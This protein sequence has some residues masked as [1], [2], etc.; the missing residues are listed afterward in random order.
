MIKY[1]STQISDLVYP[2]STILDDSLACAVW[3]AS[4]AT[5]TL[6]PQKEFYESSCRVLLLGMGADEQF[7]GYM[8]HR[9][10][11]KRKGWEALTDEL[12]LDS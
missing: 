9:T 5:G 1:R 11:L 8:R 10:I 3:F 6:Y 12:K 2:L 7:G 4:R